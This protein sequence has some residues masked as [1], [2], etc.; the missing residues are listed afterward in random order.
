MKNK[1]RSYIPFE[2]STGNLPYYE[3][4]HYILERTKSK[5]SVKTAVKKTRVSRNQTLSKMLSPVSQKQFNKI[6]FE[7]KPLYLKP[8][9]KRLLF[10]DVSLDSILNT[11]N[12]PYQSL[13]LLPKTQKFLS[14]P[15]I[16]KIY[17]RNQLKNFFLE[18]KGS[19]VVNSINQYYSSIDKF[20][21]DL[22][23]SFS[24]NLGCNAYITPSNK[25]TYQT[26]SDGHDVIVCQISGHKRWQIFDRKFG[27]PIG[28]RNYD[29]DLGSP[30]IDVI[31]HPGAFLY[32]PSGFPHKVTALDDTSLHLTFGI[33]TT[34]IFDLAE[35]F[36][37]LQKKHSLV[38]SFY[39]NF[40][41]DSDF[42]GKNLKHLQKQLHKK[43]IE[44]FSL[45]NIKY[46]HELASLKGLDNHSSYFLDYNLSPNFINRKSSTY[47]YSQIAFKILPGEFLGKRRII[48]PRN[49]FN[50][51]KKFLPILTELLSQK[52]FNRDFLISAG[53]APQEAT[54]LIT[55]LL[56]VR[57]IN[58][59]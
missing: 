9:K 12:I 3:S 34:Y 55:T 25:Q 7:K 58:E 47:C 31:L 5:A 44:L 16:K 17:S 43:L 41:Y 2:V 18:K 51:D 48:L 35:W 8:S 6:Y 23:A 45:E 28:S 32:I 24:V 29:N 52:K 21:K 56:K 19:I 57:L 26:H 53:L 42:K 4:L 40:L 14:G 15:E 22:A 11:K 39:T 13:K 36:S 1:D 59:C 33:H 46:M 37:I 54:D 10:Q 20:C 50:F 27:R 38:D 49:A 30:I